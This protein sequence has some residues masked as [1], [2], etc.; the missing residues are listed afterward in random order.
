MEMTDSVLATSFLVEHGAVT[1]RYNVYLTLHVEA[2]VSYDNALC[3][4]GKV[5]FLPSVLLSKI[6]VGVRVVHLRTVSSSLD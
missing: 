4:S 3:S 5:T 2:K 6:R 1:A